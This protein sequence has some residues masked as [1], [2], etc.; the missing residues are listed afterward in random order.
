MRL[1][2]L[3]EIA[4]ADRDVYVIPKKIG[5]ILESLL[6]WTPKYD[7]GRAFQLGATK[8]LL[9]HIALV[10]KGDKPAAL[11]TPAYIPILEKHGLAYV[12]MPNSEDN[13]ITVSMDMLYLL[14]YFRFAYGFDMDTAARHYLLGI[15]LGY[16]EDKV[17]KFIE[18]DERP[19]RW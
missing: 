1:S 16:S 6:E 4:Y 13:I 19:V 12:T 17:L 15:G 8:A 18:A 7:P 11:V 3:Y 5:N 14:E 9:E 2:K 10:I